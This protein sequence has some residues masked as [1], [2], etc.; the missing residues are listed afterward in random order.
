MSLTKIKPNCKPLFNEQTIPGGMLCDPLS[1]PDS[2][3]LVVRRVTSSGTPASSDTHVTQDTP[4]NEE[5]DAFVAGFKQICR[6][7]SV[8]LHPTSALLI[9]IPKWVICLVL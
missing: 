6:S 9:Q 3:G 7:V 8:I 4:T 1:L 2:E 5:D